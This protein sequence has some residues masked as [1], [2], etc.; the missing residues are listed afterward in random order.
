[1]VDQGVG[2]GI[3]PVFPNAV[4]VG[5]QNVPA[6]LV[7]TNLSQNV[8]PV[9]LGTITL[10]PSCADPT[11]FT[12]C[13]V[14]E[15]GVFDLSDTAV[16][17]GGACLGVTFIVVG[18]DASGQ[19]VFVPSEPVVLQPPNAGDTDTCRIGFTFD[20]LRV[21][22]IDADPPTPGVQTR[23]FATVTGS[24]P[25]F[26]AG[27]ITTL[28]GTGTGTSITTVLPA[29]PLIVTVATPTATL[30]QPISDTATVTGPAGGP[31]PTGTVTF[32]VFGPG[33]PACA[34]AP[35]FTSTVP[36]A[37]NGTANSGPFTPTQPGAYNFVAVYSGDANF[38]PATSPCGAPNETSQ[39]NRPVAT[40]VTVATE[41]TT[42]GGAITDTAQVTGPPG[43]PAPT[44]TVTFTIFGPNDPTCSGAPVFV[45]ADRPLTGG[46]ATSAPFTPPSTGTYM[47]V[48]VYSGDQ[49]FAPAVSPC[50]APNEQSNVLAAQP[51]LTTE[52]QPT[53][54][55]GQPITDTATLS[56]GFNPTGTITFNLFG[57][58]DA[59][60]AGP[61]VF[62]S[63]VP[64]NGNGNYVSGPFTPTQPGTYF[65][66]ARYSGDA[67]N[68][69][70]ANA[71]GDPN[72]ITEVFGPPT[73]QVVKTATP[74][75][76]PEPG[77]DFTY[78]VVVTNTGPN[79]LTITSLN[80][81]VYGDLTTRPNSTCTNAIGRVLAADPDGAGPATG[82]TYACSFTAP[83]TGP[84]G[85]SLT[86][87]VTVVG[88]D[89]FGQTATDNDDATVN[90]INDVPEIMV[91]KTVTPGSLPEPG[92]T[93]TYT[94]VVTNT[95]DETLTITSLTDDVYGNLATQGT[96][97]TAIGQVLDPGESYTCTFPGVFTGNAGDSETDTVTVIGV[98]DE[99]TQVTDEDDAV[100]TLTPSP[101]FPPTVQVV[102]TATPLTMGEPGGTFT[103]NVVVT[104]TSP[105]PVTITELTD[106]VYGNIANQGTCTDAV[107]KVLPVGGTYACSFP[108]QFI[109]D[110]GD[111]QTD[112]VTVVVVDDDD[113][114][115]TDD[116]DA[117]VTLT[118]VLP[119]VTVDKTAD[120]A[121][122]LA[123]GGDFTFNVKVT[124]TSLEPVT[125]TTL[126]DDV[127]G[128]LATKGTCTSAIGR[129]LQPGQTYSC[130]FTG[131]F[132]GNAGQSQTD[133]VTVVVADNE[134]NTATDTDDAVVR[135]VAPP[136]R[137]LNEQVTP[138]RPIVRGTLA[139]TGS[140]AAMQATLAGA[141]VVL[142]SLL[143]L[144]SRLTS[145]SPATAA[146]GPEPQ[147][148][149]RRRKR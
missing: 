147:R 74:L 16:G 56:G 41:S 93:F 139:R 26:V 10:D 27:Q 117:V 14:P 96:C 22:S 40:I 55:V 132:Q 83:F 123:P 29:Q 148:R 50:G 134:N 46:V 67:N 77:G 68:A 42:V 17:T 94:V 126:T 125:I 7:I 61:P 44:G 19:Y 110:A 43:A 112:V 104:N 85:A 133:V 99:G 38:A 129:V 137:V 34:G 75:T 1:M 95:G 52:A 21:P 76:R 78:D 88:T 127:Y 36:L 121:T 89:E 51:E 48:A 90:I 71:C 146:Q 32:T 86:D 105:E 4:T 81:S 63:V 5:D 15:L 57:P 91:D 116:D 80:D 25:A 59:T 2:L 106:D 97:T 144:A 101:D 13:Q 28:F 128:N 64:V 82:G 72:E 140:A 130:S 3:V 35:V 98:D 30:G 58:D 49:L 136:A 73:I 33:D 70:A 120:P 37:A 9:T 111:S 143:L 65:W 118:D 103:F 124:N 12:P 66:V 135:L 45:S 113:N 47:F 114:E 84:G 6:S 115:A 24:A 92:G 107:G 39:V 87:I 131:Q 11:A 23:Q 119:T 79:D 54:A 109:G 18:P 142:G 138:P 149:P 20:V 60:C 145:A 108:G 31:T 69:P 62:T 102:K 100:V 141:M 53:A 8:G 122:R